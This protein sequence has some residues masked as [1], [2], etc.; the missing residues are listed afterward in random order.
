MKL[1]AKEIKELEFAIAVPAF[2]WIGH[3][4]IDTRQDIL[5]EWY[6]IKEIPFIS[7]YSEY[8][9]GCALFLLEAFS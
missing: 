4:P 5:D 7:D 6:R 8:K 9:L 3:F 2:I 1:S